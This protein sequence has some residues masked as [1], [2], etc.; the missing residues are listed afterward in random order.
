MAT[1][2]KATEGP[3]NRPAKKMKAARRM[4]AKTPSLRVQ[5]E[6]LTNHLMG[7]IEREWLRLKGPLR[8]W[9]EKLQW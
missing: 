7:V 9:K 1:K 5:F 2:K 8:Q 6:F 4:R 3:A